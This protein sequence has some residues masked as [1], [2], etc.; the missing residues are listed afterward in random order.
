M[1][2]VDWQSR[3]RLTVWHRLLGV[4]LAASVPIA[5]VVYQLRGDDRYPV[6]SDDL[7]SLGLRFGAFVLLWTGLAVLVAVRWDS[8]RPARRKASVFALG[9]LLGLLLIGGSVAQQS[10]TVCACSG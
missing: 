6:R 3:E 7:R 2:A 10:A 4:C 9:A 8:M 5:I 1:T